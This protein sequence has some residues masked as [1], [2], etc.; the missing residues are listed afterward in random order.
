MEINL[1]CQNCNNDFKV[2]Y[3]QRNKK[4]C[5]RQ[6][7]F[8]FARKNNLLGKEKDNSIREKRTCLQCGKE[9][10]ERIKHQRKLCSKECREIWNKKEENK[11]YRIKKTKESL[12]EKYGVDSLYK[13][14]EF[15]KK[16]KENFV[17]KYGVNHPMYVPEF[18][19]KLKDTVRD[20]HLKNLIPSLEKNNIKLLDDY[21]VNKNGNTSL[22]YTFQCQACESIFTSTLLGSGKIP[23]C[24][25]CFPIVKNSKLELIIKDFLDQNNIKHID[26][27]RNLNNGCEIDIFLPDF[28]LGIE[29]NGNYFHSEIMG[30]KNK[31]YHLNKT[32]E[33]EK[34]DIKLIQIFEDELLLKKDITLS[35]ISNLLNLNNRI[36]ARLCEVKEVDKKTSSEFLEKNHIQGMSIDKYRFGLFYKNEL[37]SLITF[38]N[39][40]KF[41]S[42]KNNFDGE[43][44]LIR[45]CNKINTNIIGGF[46]KLLKHFIKLQNPTKIITYSDIRWS[47][48]N[49]EKTVYS[50]LGF[51]TVDITPPNYWYVDKKK[52]INRY[53]RYTFR[54]NVL[55]K[56]GYSKEK[57]EWEIMQEK[58]YDRI[59]DC[60]SIKFEMVL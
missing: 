3:K 59:W 42:K 9:F 55:I 10:D 37:V 28:N 20:R 27:K 7:Y 21:S 22:S 33:S 25:K 18:V 12:L 38:G 5:G 1:T 60:G 13:L 16:S 46:S 26:N 56:E 34:Q 41:I 35:R 45:F 44:E 15:Q 39:K 19:N 4:F 58:N 23:I 53:H 50:K 52:Y 24:R 49:P 17:L 30:E 2:P 32:I 14:D 54:K 8:D 43:Y 29:V 47:G 36:Y 48:I 40:R 51:N 57:T 31:D 6:C 11:E